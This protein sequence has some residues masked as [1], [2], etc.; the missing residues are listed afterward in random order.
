MYESK[1]TS[2]QSLGKAVKNLFAF[3]SGSFPFGHNFVGYIFV[4]HSPGNMRLCSEFTKILF[5]VFG[6][7]IVE[8]ALRLD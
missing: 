8:N 4:A 3:K 1:L 5:D 6:L 2:K 7:N